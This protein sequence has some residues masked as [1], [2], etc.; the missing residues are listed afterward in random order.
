MSSQLTVRPLGVDECWKLL[1]S[2]ELGRVAV[3]IDAM[4]VVLPVFFAV[5][6]DAIVFRTA[7]GTKLE[8]ATTE[9][10]VAFEA[11]DFDPVTREG[12]SVVVQGVAREVTDPGELDRIR[13]PHA[14]IVG[15]HGSADRYVTIP[16]TLIDGRA[17]RAVP[18][19]DVGAFTS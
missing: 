11:D 17:I 16:A 4:P 7:P 2:S 14:D 5:V 10:V 19:P 9:A 1:R 12:W 18:E 8:A 15:A 6:E 3:T 13:G